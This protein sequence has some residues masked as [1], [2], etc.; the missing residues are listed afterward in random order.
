MQVWVPNWSPDGK[1][2][3]FMGKLPG[4]TW[5]IYVV[6]AGGGTPQQLMPGEGSEADPRWSPDGSSLA[7]G[8]PPDY[9]EEAGVPK[10]IRVLDL[11]SKQVSKLPGSDGLFSPRWSPDGRYIAAMPLDHSRLLLFDLTTRKW[12]GLGNRSARNPQ[13]SGDGRY[14]YF[15]SSGT[16]PGIYRVRI[17]DRK[18][19]RILKRE[20][21]PRGDVVD[22]GSGAVTPD[23]SLLVWLAQRSADLYALEWEA[24]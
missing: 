11:E 17:S 6:P 12:E 1:Q 4:R 9:L 10:A 18:L 15:N 14:I 24:P 23:G 7:F 19:E 21:I 5:K 22:F 2:I 20:D 8:S 3:A 13:W 16:E